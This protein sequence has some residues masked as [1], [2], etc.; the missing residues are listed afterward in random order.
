MRLGIKMNRLFL[1]IFTLCALHFSL[2]QAKEDTAWTPLFNGKDFD[3][4]K[5]KFANVPYPINPESTFRVIDGNMAAYSHLP[6]DKVSFGHMFY[7][8]KT[9]SWFYM[10]MEYKFLADTVMPGFPHW[11]IQNSGL[12]FHCPPPDKMPLDLDFPNSLEMQ[13]LGPKSDQG[14]NGGGYTMNVCTPGTFVAV[15]GQDTQEHCIKAAP[16]DISKQEWI[17]ISAFVFGDSAVI[18]MVGQ[19]TVLRYGKTRY[20]GGLPAKEG[21]IALQAEGAPILFR[22]FQVLDLVGCM[23]KTSPNYKSYYRKNDAADCAKI[24]NIITKQNQKK[25]ASLIKLNRFGYPEGS[26]FLGRNLKVTSH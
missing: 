21:Y 26:Q 3:G 13:I 17:G 22:N 6:K 15:N 14:I 24:V 18:H 11:D 9:F 1:S 2:I 23:D 19:D 10:R 12:M 16:H 25:P 20:D 4:W 5:A 8:K 7:M